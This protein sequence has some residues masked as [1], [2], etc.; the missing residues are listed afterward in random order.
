MAHEINNPLEAVTNLLYLA[1]NASEATDQVREYLALAD[2]E[3]QRVGHIAKRTLAFYRDPVSPVVMDVG[4]A[5][6][7]VLGIF[8]RKLTAKGVQI[9]KRYAESTSVLCNSGEIRQVLSNVILNAIDAVP[10]GGTLQVRVAHNKIGGAGDGLRITIADNGRGIK[11]AD[12]KRIF[13]PFFTTKK[14][15]GTGL[16]LWI[17]N[18]IV[19]K[20]GGA[21]R[22]KSSTADGRS[23]TAVSIILPN[24]TIV[25]ASK[26]Q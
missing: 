25:A 16:G 3:L 23:G 7:E 1:R 2:E 22:V 15:V 26:M 18:S 5:I 13:E 8:Q 24:S 11:A 19:Q 4:A 21:I 9:K 10:E 17:S 14:D 6:D 20:H 12:R